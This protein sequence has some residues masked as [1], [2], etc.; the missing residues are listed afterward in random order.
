M[1]GQQPRDDALADPFAQLRQGDDHVL[2]A[3]LAMN[4][5]GRGLA[6]VVHH[7]SGIGSADFL[8]EADQKFAERKIENAGDDQ[9]GRR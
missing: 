7:E 3:F 2:A 4:R 9:R 8:I 6:F 5:D 1:A